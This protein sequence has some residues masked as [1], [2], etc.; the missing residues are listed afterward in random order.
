MAGA[1]RWSKREVNNLLLGAGAFGIEW[2]RAQT[3]QPYGE[4]GPKHRSEKA[5]RNKASI[6]GL[7]GLTRGAYTLRSLMRETGYTRKQLVRAQYAL[8]QKWKRSGPR[9]YFLVTED[10][11]D[12]ILEWLKHDYWCRPK[13]LYACMWCGGSRRPHYSAG[14]CG[15]CH[16]RHLRLC[17]QLGLPAG[18]M[19]QAQLVG[20]VRRR[21]VGG[22]VQFVR[23]VS[24]RLGRKL[25]LD[26]Q[27][28]TGLQV[29][30]GRLH[31]DRCSRN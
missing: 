28:L 12:D 25:A 10:Q 24:W 30:T 16:R 11:R 1:R 9:G 3:G 29:L 20:L 14:L 5:V 17:G 26:Q 13:H 7:G 19:A 21:A 23:K 4:H 8:N 6:M 18:L 31:A 22:E 15:T 2:L 27:Q